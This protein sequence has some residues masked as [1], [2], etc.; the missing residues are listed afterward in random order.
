MQI[1]ADIH[2]YIYIMCIYIIVHIY[3]YIVCVYIYT[4]YSCT[5]Y[6]LAGVKQPLLG[7]QICRALA[8]LKDFECDESNH[9]VRSRGKS[10]ELH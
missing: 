10:G 1:Y 5:L 6:V 3:I 8:S 4:H 2:V 9:K 7:G